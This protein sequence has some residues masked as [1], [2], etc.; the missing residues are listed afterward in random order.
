M[1]YILNILPSSRWMNYRC[2][3]WIDKFSF[4]RLDWKSSWHRCLKKMLIEVHQNMAR[5]YIF[6]LYFQSI[7]SIFQTNDSKFQPVGLI[8]TLKI[9]ELQLARDLRLMRNRYVFWMII[10]I[11]EWM[12]GHCRIDWYDVVMATSLCD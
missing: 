5:R 12:W 4:H 3:K 2:C 8:F 1:N 10:L 7:L 11:V 6:S 9:S